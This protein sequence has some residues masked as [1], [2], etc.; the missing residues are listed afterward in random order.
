MKNYNTLEG[1]EKYYISDVKNILTRYTE[2]EEGV[3]YFKDCLIRNSFRAFAMVNINTG[4]YILRC[5]PCDDEQYETYKKFC[6][7]YGYPEWV[8]LS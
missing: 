5:D 6:E 1:L 7:D 4:G 3:Y 2:S 8:V